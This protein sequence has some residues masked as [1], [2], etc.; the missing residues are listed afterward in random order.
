MPNAVLN[1]VKVGKLEGIGLMRQ[2]THNEKGISQTNYLLNE[3]TISENKSGPFGINTSDQMV[4]S[5]QNYGSNQASFDR[6]QQNYGLRKDSVASQN[7][8]QRPHINTTMSYLSNSTG[9]GGPH[10]LEVDSHHTYTGENEGYQ[11]SRPRPIQY[12]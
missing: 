1:H 5:S 8:N 12:G 9:G 3:R 4:F 10:H 11:N 6:S 7:F 2:A